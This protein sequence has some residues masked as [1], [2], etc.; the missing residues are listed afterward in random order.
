VCVYERKKSQKVFQE[1]IVKTI[2]EQT[3]CVHHT[4]KGNAG[5]NEQQPIRNN[6]T[7]SATCDLI[8]R[9][10]RVVICCEEARQDDRE[11]M[12][13][14]CEKVALQANSV[15]MRKQVLQLGKVIIAQS[16]GRNR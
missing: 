10:W 2:V 7:G 6:R 16:A 11:R 8:R 4:P 14:D 3:R 13:V 12:K 15:G 1:S 9:T 5:C